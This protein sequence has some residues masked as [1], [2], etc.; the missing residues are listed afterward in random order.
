MIQIYSRRFKTL[1]ITA[2]FIM[3][4]ACGGEAPLAE[5]NTASEPSAQTA[6]VT[7]PTVSTQAAPIPA[8][9]KQNRSSKSLNVQVMG[10]SGK[11]G[12]VR[13]ALFNSQS[14]YDADT[15]LQG[16]SLEA[17]GNSITF[18]FK[19]LSPGAYAYK[20]FLDE[21]KDREIDTNALGIPTEDYA[22]SQDASAP[23]S[24]P[25]WADAKFNLSEDA[26]TSRQITLD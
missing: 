3:L 8:P 21:N 5:N 1:S 24:A 22:F 6:A 14:T 11:T 15:P 13:I 2:G 10:L 12:I 9:I 20:L 7:A 25:K 4:T 17:S 23:F 18:E 16:K 19:D 26:V